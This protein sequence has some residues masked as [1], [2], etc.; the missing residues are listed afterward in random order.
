MTGFAID[1]SHHLMLGCSIAVVVMMLLSAVVQ[2]HGI[3][4]N[5][6]LGAE[7]GFVCAL[8][9]NTAVGARFSSV[10]LSNPWSI[11][12][13]VFVCGFA[14]ALLVG[15]AWGM[16]SLAF[17]IIA[18][19]VFALIGK[20]QFDAWFKETFNSDSSDVWSIAFILI[21]MVILAIIGHFLKKQEWLFELVSVISMASSYAFSSNII[22]QEDV[23]SGFS[24]QTNIELLPFSSI[25]GDVVFG[26]TFVSYVCAYYR[27]FLKW[28]QRH[29]S[30]PPLE[31]ELRPLLLEYSPWKPE[32]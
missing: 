1:D 3:L 25:T 11:F 6:T 22:V 13:V 29:S 24:N 5:I 10:Y 15:S 2:H 21:G 26:A 30:P 16:V 27:P 18:M 32:L 28:P 4:V 12:A 8:V 7:V 23:Y 31:E 17:A 19:V 9:W 20:P 14:G